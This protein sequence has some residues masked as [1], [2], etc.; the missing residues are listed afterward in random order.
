MKTKTTNSE[1]LALIR[2]EV[3]IK[4]S[5]GSIA[6][7]IRLNDLRKKMADFLARQYGRAEKISSPSH[8]ERLASSGRNSAVIVLRNSQWL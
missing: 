2:E 6:K 4:N 3:A 5:P 8:G 1:F 7:D